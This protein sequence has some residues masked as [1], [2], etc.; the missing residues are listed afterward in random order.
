VPT[1]PQPIRLSQIVRRAAEIVDPDDDDAVVGDFERVFEDADE[2]V[3]GVLDDI[4][5]RVGTALAELDPAV[6]NGSLSMAG[7]LT[8]YLSFRRDE[9]NAD[10]EE[11]IRLAT[12]AEWEGR[13]P[14]AVEDWLAARGISV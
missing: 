1:E 4:E 9:L 10:D 6:A 3:T 8:I 14:A 13:P 11:L 12:R 7:A 2:P 5:T